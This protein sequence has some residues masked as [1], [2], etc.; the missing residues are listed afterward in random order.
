MSECQICE[1]CIEDGVEKERERIVRLLGDRLVPE[2]LSIINPAVVDYN[3]LMQL[4]IDYLVE[5]PE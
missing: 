2:V 4:I 1:I 3:K 5:E